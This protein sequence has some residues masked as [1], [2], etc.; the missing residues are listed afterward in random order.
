MNICTR[1]GS[2]LEEWW[3]GLIVPIWK[4]KGDVQAKFKRITLLSHGKKVL[5]RILDGRMR[6]NVEIEIGEEQEGFRKVRGRRM[7]CSC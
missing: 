1:E 6:K 7:I 3:T 4:G 2:I 5:E